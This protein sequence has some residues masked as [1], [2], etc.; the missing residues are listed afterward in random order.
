M[1][2]GL[3]PM[4]EHDYVKNLISK[5]KIHLNLKEQNRRYLIAA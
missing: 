1:P 5:A 4:Q 3:D 2:L